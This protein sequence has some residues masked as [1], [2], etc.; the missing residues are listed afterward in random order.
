MRVFSDSSAIF[1]WSDLLVVLCPK[2]T[3][4]TIEKIA[5]DH[6]QVFQQWLDGGVVGNFPLGKNLFFNFCHVVAG[7]RC[8]SCGKVFDGRVWNES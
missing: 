7:D 4:K 6:A 5:A 2:D 1:S 3:E 8:Q